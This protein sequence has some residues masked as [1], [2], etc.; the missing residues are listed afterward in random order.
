MHLLIA[1]SLFSSVGYG[2]TDLTDDFRKI[3]EALFELKDADQETLS[4]AGQQYVQDG[5]ASNECWQLAVGTF[6]WSRCLF[7]EGDLE[8]ADSLLRINQ[9]CLLSIPHT[10]FQV[11]T[12]DF[13]QNDYASAID[14]WRLV[15]LHEWGPSKSKT[16]ENIGSCWQRLGRLDSAQHYYEKSLSLQ[17]DQVGMMTINNIISVLNNRGLQED[18]EAFFKIGSNLPVSDSTALDMLYWNMISASV[19]LNDGKRANEVF[20]EWHLRGFKQ[21]KSYAFAIYTHLLLLN[22]DMEGFMAQLE[23]FL[24]DVEAMEGFK[25]PELE[26]LV[27]APEGSLLDGLSL[28]Q[29]WFI[30]REFFLSKVGES[31]NERE[32][33]AAKSLQMK[34]ERKLEEE[35]F[36]NRVMVLGFLAFLLF[37]TGY[38]LVALGQR[39]RRSQTARNFEFGTHDHKSVQ[40]IR[41]SLVSQSNSEV[42]LAQLAELRELLESKQIGT[43]NRWAEGQGL[44]SSEFRLLELIGKGYSAAECSSLMDC[45]K[46]HIYNL[47]S[48][49]RKKLSLP[50]SETLKVWVNRQLRS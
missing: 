11:A 18:V 6:L 30:S 50:E 16:L 29:R 15:L 24:H 45:T 17:G 4:E 38:V 13:F 41:D 37:A 19:F 2:Q 43:L 44:T 23:L 12:M 42:A 20:E 10:A 25:N 21:I 9:P 39:K 8:T 36:W 26:L 7:R 27:D 14:H 28:E 46:S 47:R 1:L 35:Q 3:D 34:L 40:L 22:D 49:I 33:Q 32:V 48:S 31:E 5:M